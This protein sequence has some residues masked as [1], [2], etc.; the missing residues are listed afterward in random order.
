[1]TEKTTPRVTR[2]DKEP[3]LLFTEDEE[4]FAR[5]KEDDEIFF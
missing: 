3:Q 5:K 1:L 2:D 4:R